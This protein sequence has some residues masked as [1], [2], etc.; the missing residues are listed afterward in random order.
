MIDSN[1]QDSR[2]HIG[3]TGEEFT[4]QW[5]RNQGYQILAQ[6]YRTRMGELDIVAQRQ[7]TVA[8]VEVKTRETEY[9]PMSSLIVPS[10]QRKIIA[11]AKRYLFENQFTNQK[12]YRFDIALV[13]GNYPHYSISYIENAF[14]ERTY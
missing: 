8:F 6:N 5:L 1:G 10:K 4:C 13:Q 14:T 2:L 11:T 7:E 3:K 9:F 12:I